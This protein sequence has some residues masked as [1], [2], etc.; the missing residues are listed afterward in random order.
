[1]FKKVNLD[2]YKRKEHFE[3]YTQNI[4]C[5]FELTVKLNI[6]SFYSFICKNNLKFYPCWIYCISKSVNQFEEFRLSLDENEKLICYDIIHPSYTI[7]HKDTKTFSVLWTTYQKD[8]KDFLNLY[9]EDI[10]LLENNKQM[11]IK[12]IINNTFNISAIP[13]IAFENFSLHLPKKDKYYF[14]IFTSG[15]IIKENNN[16][17][18][19]FSINVNHA[20]NDAYHV[21]MFLNKLQQE[22][23]SL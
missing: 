8:L 10:R 23:D 22:L 3:F 17:L 1:M 13:W 4:P 14:P 12:N 6:T 20:V 5:S 11:F 2:K 15:K 18:I 19:P 9:E 7:F 21:S 16:I